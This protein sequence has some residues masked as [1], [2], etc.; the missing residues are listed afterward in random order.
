MVGELGHVIA[1]RKIEGIRFV[2]HEEDETLGGNLSKTG[3]A[4]RKKTALD[5]TQ[6]LTLKLA[7]F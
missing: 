3:R 4:V 6:Q 7:P 2:Q 1:K 5:V